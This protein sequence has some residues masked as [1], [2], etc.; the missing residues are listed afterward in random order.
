MTD[1]HHGLDLSYL[2]EAELDEA[3]TAAFYSTDPLELH[4]LVRQTLVRLIREVRMHRL[5]DHETE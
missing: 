3:E 5:E 1:P 4:R 2:S